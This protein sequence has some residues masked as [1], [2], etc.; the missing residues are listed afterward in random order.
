MERLLFA[1]L[2]I[3]IAMGCTSKYNRGTYDLY[4]IPEGYEG[5]IRVIYNVKNAPLLERE[6]K[7]DVI[8]VKGNGKYET[9]TPMYDYGEVID[10]YYYV[11][12]KGNRTELDPMCVSVLGTGG[13]DNAQGETHHTLIEVTHSKCG[14]DFGLWGSRK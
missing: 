3:A 6:G 1:I 9:S 11:D 5:T 4:L 12:E 2:F 8:P 10:R 14:K 7:Y 13:T